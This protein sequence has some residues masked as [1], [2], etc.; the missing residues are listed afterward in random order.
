MTQHLAEIKTYEAIELLFR[1]GKLANL[2]LDFTTPNKIDLEAFMNQNYIYNIPMSKFALLTG[3]SLATFK[4]DFKK[5]FHSSPNKWIIQK[6]LER[7]HFLIAKQKK[8][9]ATV[10]NDVGFENFSHFSTAFK[11]RFGYSTSMLLSL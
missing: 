1:H 10:Y 3:R 7:A 2:L 9:P 4:R 6:W 8:T 11:K 5:V